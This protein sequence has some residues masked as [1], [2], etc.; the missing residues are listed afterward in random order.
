MA[1]TV[2]QRAAAYTAAYPTYPP[3][4]THGRW[5]YGIWEVGAFYRSNGFYGAYPHGYLDRL[6]ALFPDFPPE[7]WWHVFSGSLDPTTPGVR[8]DVHPDRAPDV[9]ADVQQLS[10]VVPLGAID[11]VAADPPYSVADATNYD[12]PM[13]NRRQV[14]AELAYC[15]RPGGMLAWLDTVK[16]M[17]R[18]KDWRLWGEIGIAGSTNH[19]VRMVFLFER[20]AYAE[21][22]VAWPT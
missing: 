11:F 16:P 17:Y 2:E 6:R 22:M 10:R 12:V 18:A 1:L 9:L 13:P 19:R 5:L 8:V 21:E 3:L 20:E 4:A 14:M 15:V 7:T